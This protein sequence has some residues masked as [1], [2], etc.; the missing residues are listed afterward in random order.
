MKPNSNRLVTKK[1]VK[2][3]EAAELLGISESSVRRLIDRGIL[4][5]SRVLRHLLIPATQIDE[6]LSG[7]R[8][9][10]LNETH[11]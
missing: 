7:E 1:A 8:N 2:I 10:T 9:A 11:N 6:I 5:P 4:K 3:G